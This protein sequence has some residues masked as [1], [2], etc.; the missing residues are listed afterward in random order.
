VSSAW[1]K[2]YA[3]FIKQKEIVVK[4]SEFEELVRDPD[5]SDDDVVVAFFYYLDAEGSEFDQ[6]YALIRDERHDAFKRIREVSLKICKRE[7]VSLD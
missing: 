3:E 4:L 2:L 6:A 5:K 1:S 7:G